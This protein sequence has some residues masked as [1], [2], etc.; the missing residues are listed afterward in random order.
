[1]ELR[2]LSVSGWG[3]GSLKSVLPVTHNSGT[4]DG[5]SERAEGRWILCQGFLGP[6]VKRTGETTYPPNE[7]R[8]G[9]YKRKDDRSTEGGNGGGFPVYSGE[10]SPEGTRE[11]REDVKR[12]I[13]NVSGFNG[14]YVYTVNRRRRDRH[15][16]YS[17]LR[18]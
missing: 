3:D 5:C 12:N 17:R 11:G 1:M 8:P 4:R 18:P 16:T 7:E 2:T 14:L 6:R 15:S 10:V 13:V 9:P